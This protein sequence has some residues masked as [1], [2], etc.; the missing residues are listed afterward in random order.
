MRDLLL[1]MQHFVK[2]CQSKRRMGALSEALH[3]EILIKFSLN[4]KSPPNITP[5]IR[6]SPS[7][8]RLNRKYMNSIFVLFTLYSQ[9][10]YKNY[11][12]HKCMQN[13]HWGQQCTTTLGI[14]VVLGPKM[15]LTWCDLQVALVKF[16]LEGAFTVFIRSRKYITML[17]GCGANFSA[18]YSCPA[19]SFV[20]QG[21]IAWK[22]TKRK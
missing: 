10:I 14:Q 2:L 17:T 19:K 8:K 9:D 22:E 4:S 12:V 15:R 13:R 6:V 5:Y 18:P 20:V 3:V 16:P 7:R 11:T 1:D 21:C